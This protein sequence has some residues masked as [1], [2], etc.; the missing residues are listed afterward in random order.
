MVSG[1][2]KDALDP[3][4][5]GVTAL[6]LVCARRSFSLLAPF[7]LFFFSRNPPRVPDQ[8]QINRG[9]LPNFGFGV[10]K[11]SAQRPHNKISNSEIIINTISRIVIRLVNE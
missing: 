8:D 3:N 11:R 10:A 9:I 6:E 2:K 7:Y 1:G 4:P 5:V